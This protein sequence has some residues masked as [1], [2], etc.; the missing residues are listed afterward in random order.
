MLVYLLSEP[1]F[2]YIYAQ[3]SKKDLKRQLLQ[4]RAG[5]LD[6]KVVK[7][8]K[9]HSDEAIAERCLIMHTVI[10]I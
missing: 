2:C 3:D 10:V 8:S 7:P 6:E 1:G 4:V 9:M 5:L